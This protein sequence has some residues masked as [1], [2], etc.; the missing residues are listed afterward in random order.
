MS[1]S[2]S[3]IK[4][5]LKPAVFAAGLFPLGWIIWAGLTGNL[6]ANPAQRHHERNRSLGAALHLHHPGD[7]AAAPADR[8]ESDHPVPADG[9]TLR[10]LLRLPPLPHLRHRRSVRRPR[11]PGRHRRLEHG[12]EPDQVGGRGHLQAAVHHHRLHGADDDAAAGVD[13]H[14]RHDPPAGREAV[15]HAA[16]A[17]LRHG[18]DCRHP[19]LVAGEGRRDQPPAVRLRRGRAAAGADSVRKIPCEDPDAGAVAAAVRV[20][21]APRP[22]QMPAPP[23]ARSRVSGQS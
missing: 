10:L 15:E 20:A 8:L 19:L 2:P 7:H 21:A 11:L 13:L 18:R 6:S 5:V 17:D 23:H 22:Q 3:V 9:R 16:P 12:H 4:W 14:G 1:L